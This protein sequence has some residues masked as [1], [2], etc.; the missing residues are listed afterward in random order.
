MILMWKMVMLRFETKK[1]HAKLTGSPMG[2]WSPFQPLLPWMK[3]LVI[4]MNILLKLQIVASTRTFP[5]DNSLFKASARGEVSENLCLNF[6]LRLI[7]NKTCRSG[8]R[9]PERIPMTEAKRN[10][11]TNCH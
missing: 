9:D 11:E 4:C 3:C 7:E 6:G 1:V 2:P 5:Q 10:F 8:Q